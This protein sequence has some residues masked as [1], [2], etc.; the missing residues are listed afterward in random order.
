MGAGV[1][2]VYDGEELT[3]QATINIV[4][5]NGFTIS[6]DAASEA[7]DEPLNKAQVLAIVDPFIAG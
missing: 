7:F 5:L 1:Q 4:N 3:T 2:A 6:A